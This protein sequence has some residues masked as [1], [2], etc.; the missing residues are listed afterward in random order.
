VAI[1]VVVRPT[2]HLPKKCRY[3]EDVGDGLV[4]P[5]TMEMDEGR[6]S[7]YKT[8]GLAIPKYLIREAVLRIQK[9]GI[10]ERGLRG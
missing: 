2:K 8:Y 1:Y 3:V 5:V 7:P 9:G 4:Q 6:Y 10:D